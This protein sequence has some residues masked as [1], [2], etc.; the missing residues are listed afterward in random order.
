SFTWTNATTGG[1]P[2]GYRVYCDTNPNPTTLIGTA[3]GSPYTATTPLNW[4]TTYYW[5][6]VPFNDAGEA[7]GNAI[8]SFTVRPNP[9][10]S[11]FPW[12]VDFGTVAGDWPVAN[13]SQLSGF[14]P[15]PTGTTAQ[16]FQD[17]WLNITAP[18]NKAAKINIYGTT[19]YGWLVTP[20]I[21]IPATD[22]E[23]NFDAALMVWNSL[24][25]PVTPGNQADD[26]FM[27]IVSDTPT[28]TNPTILREWNNTSSPW[29]LDNISPTGENFTIPLTGIT[30]TKFIAFYGESTVSNGDNDLMID[31]LIVRQTSLP[32]TIYVTPD[33][34]DFGQRVIN[35]AT[36]KSF[37]VSNIGVG[38]LDIS[39]ISITGNYYGIITNPAPVSLT[40]GQSVQIVVEYLPTAFGSH[41][42]TLI[43][44]DNRAITEI[45]LTATCYDP[46]ITAFPYNQ[47]FETW[48]PLGWDL[49]GGSHSFVQFTA[50]NGN[51]WARANFWNQT[52]GFTDIMTTPLINS[53]DPLNL[54]FTWSHLYN[55]SYP[56]DALTVQ[57]SLDLTN[58]TNIWHKGGM[59]LNSNDGAGN[60]TPG[61]G[62][63][64]TIIILE[65]HTRDPFYIRFFAYSGYGPDLFI[66]NVILDPIIIIPPQISVSPLS[67][68]S[69]I[70]AG[71][72]D[73]QYLT[74]TNSGGEPLVFSISLG[75]R[76]VHRDPQT[77]AL[78]NPQQGTVP[79]GQ[80][81]Q[82]E[83]TFDGINT[84]AGHYL[85]NLIIS[86]NAGDPVS[87]AL[88]FT[89]A[90]IPQPVFAI[91]PIEWNYGTI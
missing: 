62:I 27:I 43:I 89:V 69:A 11:T 33:S 82:I 61:T 4:N 47:D 25:T 64:E 60:T 57:V 21:A 36:T 79:A 41:N 44:S 65:E 6:V 18:A 12:V 59:D 22:Y 66:D 32:P 46:T 48:P 91:D 77:W 39:S 76:G 67:L 49:T 54:R 87:V 20:P 29:I 78:P 84:P 45:P 53:P 50:T 5:K 51:K 75:S 24:S 68:I 37:T 13:W 81:L 9:T 40:N 26:K 17:D 83:V 63:E 52:A 30:G 80:S 23:L 38:S 85:G 15:T 56:L 1:V 42:G 2:N 16:W 88:D 55:A 34:W 70:Y 74:I 58:W 7:E 3:T 35:T 73:T 86:N 10:I 71:E 72:T 28:M 8:R 31:N 19:R 14:Y 90:S